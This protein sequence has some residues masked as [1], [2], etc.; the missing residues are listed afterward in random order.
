ML[1]F[2]RYMCV[3]KYFRYDVN[4]MLFTLAGN[5][6]MEVD[7]FLILPARVRWNQILLFNLFLLFVT[8][9]CHS[10][11]VDQLKMSGGYICGLAP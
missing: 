5:S 6:L 7:S 2:H 1:F 3:I 9:I 8:P 10:I 11:I 4:M